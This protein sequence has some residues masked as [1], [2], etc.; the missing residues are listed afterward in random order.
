[1]EATQDSH[2]GKLILTEL[3]NCINGLLWI[4][5]LTVQ[6]EEP[7]HQEFIKEFPQNNSANPRIVLVILVKEYIITIKTPVTRK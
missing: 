5:I 2:S 1:M 4:L 6:M 7:F 3:T